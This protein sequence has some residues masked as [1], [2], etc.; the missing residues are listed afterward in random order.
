ML[1]ES[2]FR[3]ADLPVGDRFDAWTER[4]GRTHAPMELA[5]DRS[6]DYRARLRLIQ[7]GDV[8]LWP[9]TFDPLVFR[10]TPKLIRRSDPEV[11]HLSLLQRGE[12]A[13]TWAGREVAYGVD[14]FHV[15]CSSWSYE[16]FTGPDPVTTIGVE[17]PRSLIALPAHQTDKVIGRRISGR[18]GFGALLAQFLVQL[19]SDTDSYQPADAP[20]LGTVAAD[21]V[22]AVAAHVLESDVRLPPEAHGRA[23]TLRVKAFVRRNLAD[24]ELTPATIAA[25]HHISRSYLHRLFQTE[26][27]TVAG[28]VREQR[29]RNARRDLTDPALRTRPIHVIAARWG[30]PRAAEFTRAFRTAY[31]VPPSEVRHGSP[32]QAGGPDAEQ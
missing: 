7:L 23:L 16:I 25:A 13:A 11:L 4:L 15:N 26:G 5:S 28:Y 22:T 10:R 1:H 9:S 21:L 18:E 31:G 12:G 19:A 32:R 29:L 30:F 20:R 6:A 24:P 2:L 17:I 14:D 27:I 8:T 3:T